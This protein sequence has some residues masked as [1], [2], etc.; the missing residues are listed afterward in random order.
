MGI[1]KVKRTFPAPRYPAGSS[2]K[3]M[4]QTQKLNAGAGT[5][6]IRGK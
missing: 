4:R 6:N 5:S 3:I 2:E 1:G